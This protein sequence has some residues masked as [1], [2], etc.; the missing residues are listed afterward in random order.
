MAPEKE[1]SPSPT[2]VWSTGTE[3][4]EVEV[5]V[6]GEMYSVDVDIAKRMGIIQGKLR[7]ILTHIYVPTHFTV[8]EGVE[9]DS[10]FGL[11][12]CNSRDFER[13][14]TFCAN[15]RSSSEP[16]S[17]ELARIIKETALPGAD[18]PSVPPASKPTREASTSAIQKSLA[19]LAI[20]D[21][22][23][24]DEDDENYVPSESEDSEDS[25]SDEEVSDT[26]P[27]DIGTANIKAERDEYNAKQKEKESPAV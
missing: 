8:T 15:D 4:V 6:T 25:D 7:V 27:T 9:F 16:P 24:D 13:A 17:P 3:Q 11:T 23:E 18:T 2:P 10:P 22:D 14:L 20:A 1:S 12:G 26:D 21:D 19:D 5:V